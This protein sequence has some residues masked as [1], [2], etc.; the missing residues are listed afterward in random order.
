M[1]PHDLAEQDTLKF[2]CHHCNIQ[3]TVSSSLAGVT[4]PCPSCG[5]NVAAPML[6]QGV[7]SSASSSQISVKPREFKK[8]GGDEID[9]QES[10]VG[11][12]EGESPPSSEPSRRRI[13]QDRGGRSVSPHTGISEGHKDKKEVVTILKMLFAALMVGLIVVAVVYWLKGRMGV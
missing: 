12:S 4:G 3:L 10:Q 11:E 13:S 9:R 5:M 7:D 2:K 1:P 8:S 6:G